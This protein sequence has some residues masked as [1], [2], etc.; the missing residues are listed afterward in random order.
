LASFY[1]E[2]EITMPPSPLKKEF[3]IRLPM[4]KARLAYT[5]QLSGNPEEA[6]KL[7]EKRATAGA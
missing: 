4:M 5:Y 1:R 3:T 2:T 7:Y 6:A